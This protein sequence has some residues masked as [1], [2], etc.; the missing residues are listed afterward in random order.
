[1][2]FFFTSHCSSYVERHDDV[3]V[4]TAANEMLFELWRNLISA[5]PGS[6]HLEMMAIILK[7]NSCL[8]WTY[9]QVL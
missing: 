1:M 8:L 4:E 6:T 2:N 5:G 3:E 9:M 7:N